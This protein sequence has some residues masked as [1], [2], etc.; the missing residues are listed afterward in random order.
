MF[1]TSHSVFALSAKLKLMTIVD[2]NVWIILE[3]NNEW[4]PIYVKLL[5][6]YT[7]NILVKLFT[8]ARRVDV[9][10]TG[11]GQDMVRINGEDNFPIKVTATSAK[12]M[13]SQS[14]PS[15]WLVGV[16]RKPQRHTHMWP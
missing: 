9:L 4:T 3:S 7:D 14:Q 6:T 12:F 10:K 5:Q 8:Y 16:Y 2:V 15:S 11:H 13:H 1:S